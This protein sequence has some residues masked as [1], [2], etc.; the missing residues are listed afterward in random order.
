MVVSLGGAYAGKVSFLP[1][2]G[3]AEV[4]EVLEVDHGDDGVDEEADEVRKRDVRDA[5]G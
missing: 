1:E 3:A 4:E 5:V 2:D